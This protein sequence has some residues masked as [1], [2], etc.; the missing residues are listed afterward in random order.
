[1]AANTITR[2][3]LRR[4]AEL[5][6]ERGLVLSV[7][8]N[9]DPS[10][11]AH[12]R[13]ARDRGQLGGD[14]RRAQGRRGRGTRATTSA[15][16][17]APTSSACARCCAGPT[18]RRT[19]RTASPS[20]PAGRPT[21]LEVVRLAAPDRVARDRRRPPVRRA[22]RAHR[23]RASAGAC[24][25]ST[26]GR[27][28]SSSAPPTASRR[29]TRSRTTRTASTTRAAGRRRAT[30]RSVEQEKLNH[31]GGAARHAVHALQAAPVRPPRRRRAARSSSARSR[32]GC[33]RTCARGSP[34]GSAIDVEN[35]SAGAVRAAAAEVVD[36]HV[37]AV[38]REALDRMQQGIGRGDRGVSRP[39]AVMEAL[40]QARVEILLLAEDFD[41]PGA[42]R[43][44]REGD[45]A[46]GAGDRRAPPR[47]P[48]DARRDRRCASLLSVARALVIVDFQNDFT[49]GGALAVARRRRD[50]RARRRARP[51]RRVR[52]R[53]RH[54]RLA[55]ARPRLV[56][57]PG[58]PVAGALRPGH[59]RRRAAPGA[60]PRARRRR[61]RQGPGP[62]DRGLLRLRGDEPRRAAAR[63]R[64]RPR[65][66]RRPGDRL[67]RQEHGARRAA[68]RLR[69]DGR[70]D[71]GARGRA[72]AGRR[73]ARAR[74]GARRRRQHRV[75]ID[76]PPRRMG[77]SS[78]WDSHQGG[79]MEQHHG[80]ESYFVVGEGLL[81]ESVGGRVSPLEAAAAAPPFRFSRMGP[82]GAG[83]QLP[84]GRAQEA[85]QRDDR[86]AAA[87]RRGSRPASP[88]SA[89]SSTTT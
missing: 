62:R 55:S 76:T 35:S 5:R 15:R 31:L 69:R 27:R 80:S 25:S 53:R 9:L 59:A 18:S 37:A 84:R 85:R 82:R 66:G 1:M 78:D 29:S 67:L 71:R 49:P 47:R 4:L 41:A 30:Q 23:R 87:E 52:P 11:F 50:R 64:H 44:A 36:R 65:H 26:A 38:E 46:V 32:S 58:R 54:A 63:A 3:R 74:G 14:R 70:L 6:P 56:R 34:G 39:G 13:R 28:G 20:S 51:L 17:C 42:R 86:R 7:F 40:E 89:S 81:D 57:R 12:P 22:A 60:R 77:G 19:A 73:R 48:R 75:A 10:E 21:L 45:H 61:R 2:G 83:V 43:R 24:C 68:Q 16:R 88:T 72:R 33:T 8:F 79:S